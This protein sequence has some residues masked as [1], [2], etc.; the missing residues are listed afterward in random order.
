MDPTLSFIMTNL[1][2]VRA[3]DLVLDPFCGTGSSDL[4]IY[5]KKNRGEEWKFA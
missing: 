4:A 2:K 1:A 3:G 5:E